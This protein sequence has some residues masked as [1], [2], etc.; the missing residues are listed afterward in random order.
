LR[1]YGGI[2]YKDIDVSERIVLR[3]LSDMSL[4]NAERVAFDRAHVELGDEAE[5]I[6]TQGR[7]RFEAFMEKKGG[8][9]YGSTTAPGSRA[10]VVLTAQESRRQGE[11]LR[12]FV[13]VQAGHGG[14][15]LAERCVRLAVFARLSNTMTGSGKLRLGTARAVANL[16]HATPPV[17]IHAVAC[18]G[19][20]MPLTWLAAP[21]ADLPLAIGEAMALINGSPFATAMACDVALT[22]RRRVKLAE[23][24]FAMSVEAARCPA[25]HFDRRLADGWKDPY[26]KDSLD[27][28][29]AL[30]SQ[31][32]R[33]QLDHQAPTSWRVLP[34]VLAGALQAQAEVANAA[35]IGLQSLKDN[36]TF[37][38]DAVDGGQDVVVS[39]GG[40]HDH[41]AAKSIDQVNSVMTDLCVLASRQIAHLLDGGGLGLPPLLAQKGDG[42]GAEYLAWGL[43]EPLAAA[44][45]AAEATTLDVGLQDPAGNQSDT[46]SLGFIA[47]GK[48]R[49]VARAFDACFASLAVTAAL[50]LE[51]R[52]APLPSALRPFGELITKTVRSSAR[53]VDAGGEPLR[54]IQLLLR[55]SSD[56]M[57]STDFAAF[58]PN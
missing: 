37:L 34:N 43:T 44:R 56:D 48:H 55:E 42:V 1:T 49:V 52:D 33:I 14:E 22:M 32:E 54:Q 8:Y 11:I 25:T 6:I 31:S 29:H 41:R 2:P 39:S 53:R 20:V 51:F 58:V 9:V 12:N 23:R 27:R 28:M 30:L 19:E 18:S 46:A 7:A 16:L 38:R 50:A 36:P 40:Y 47:Y 21:I 4:A 57:T 45:R 10:K 35:Q 26:Y 3:A 13:P 5:A 24:I 15:M 17:P